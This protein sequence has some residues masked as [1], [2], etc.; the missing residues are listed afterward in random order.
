QYERNELTAAESA[1]RQARE[2]GEFMADG[3]MIR[4]ALFRLAPLCQLTGDAD[5]AQV[6]WQQ[7]LATDDTVEEPLIEL[8][9]VRS[10]LMLAAVADEREAL[11][12]A[13]HWANRYRQGQDS[14]NPYITAFAH[15]LVAWV[16]LL[17]GQPAQALTRLAPLLDAA[18][19]AGH[20]Q[21]LIQMLA[22]QALAHAAAGDSAAAHTR[23]HQLLRLTA[24]EGYIRVYLDMGE[25]MYDL[26]D[27]L[28][29]SS[30]D[31]AL[32]DYKAQLLAAFAALSGQ[33]SSAAIPPNETPSPTIVNRKS[34]IVNLVEPLSEREVEIL[35]LVADG[36]S[37]SQLA[38]EIIVTLGTVKKHL[39]NIYG[40]LGVASRTQAIARGRELGLLND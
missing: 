19:A 9:Q 39:N 7:A 6:L 24:P 18:R 35:Q 20:V 5:A 40:K 3:T 13:S 12:K 31:A 16:D 30:T 33:P 32:V 1:L 25:P 22:I 15:T 36:L 8:E 34:Q 10:W 11:A 21:Q 17:A 4:R 23:L 14:T 27:G 29:I 2:L 28:R 38:E 37:N 26:L